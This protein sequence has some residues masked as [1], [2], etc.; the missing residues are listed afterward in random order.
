MA[1]KPDSVRPCD[2]DDHSSGPVVA[3]RLKPPTRTPGRINP[4][5]VPRGPYLALLLAGLAVPFRLPGL[6]WALTPPFHPYPGLRLG[7][8]ISVALS[9]GLLRPGV[10]RRRFTLESGLSSSFHPRSSGHPHRRH[11]QSTSGPVKYFDRAVTETVSGK[12]GFTSYGPARRWV[13]TRHAG[14]AWTSRGS[15]QP[16]PPKNLGPRR[17]ANLSMPADNLR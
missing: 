9:L 6:R 15:S 14:S 16:E 4:G 2:P 7:G 12:R 17:A 1:Y 3:N 10:T 13:Q 5:Q 11:M 8:F